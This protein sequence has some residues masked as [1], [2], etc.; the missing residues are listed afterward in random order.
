MIT[1]IFCFKFFKLI[2]KLNL[3]TIQSSFI[4]NGDFNLQV[5]DILKT[6]IQAFNS[7]VDT[8]N[9]KQH[10]NFT[11]HIKGNTLDLFITLEECKYKINIKSNL[12]CSISIASNLH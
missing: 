7:V 11:T 12:I 2:L 6:N 5:D 8:F 10:V 1:A 4:I 3:I 9:L